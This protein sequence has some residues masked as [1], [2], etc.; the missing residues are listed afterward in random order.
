MEHPNGIYSGRLACDGEGNLLA[1]EATKIGEKTVVITDDT[2]EPILDEAGQAMTVAVPL[3]KF[4][5]N[6][7]KPVAFHDGSYVFLQ[8]G[9]P[10]HNDRHELNVVEMTG[11]QDKNP[12]QPG[13]AGTQDDPVEG[14]EHHWGPLEDDPHFKEGAPNNT[15]IVNDP[16][17]VAALITSHTDAPREES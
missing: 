8:P 11:T 10:S 4:G 16:D 7:G 2:G 14:H 3:F 5:K 13:Y 6:H 1:H 9:E 12:D 15:K 17:K